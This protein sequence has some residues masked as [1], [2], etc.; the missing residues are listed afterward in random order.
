MNFRDTQQRNATDQWLRRNGINVAHIYAGS[1]ELF[2][3]TKLATTTLRDWS[4]VMDSQQLE[5]VKNFLSAT[6]VVR[7]R[8]RI[9][10][11]QCFKIMNIAKAAQRKSAKLSKARKAAQQGSKEHE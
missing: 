8:A 10:Q 2:Q 7:S 3:A 11:G 9:S 6:R 4:H 1:T 5:M